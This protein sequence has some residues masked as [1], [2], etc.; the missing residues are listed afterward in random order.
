MMYE[1]LCSFKYNSTFH[2]QKINKYKTTAIEGNNHLR[3]EDLF[4]T[5]YDHQKVCFR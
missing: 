4:D 2:I 1:K 5:F 3:N